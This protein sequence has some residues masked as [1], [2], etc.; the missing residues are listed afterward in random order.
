VLH[1]G[2]SRDG[3]GLLLRDI[4]RGEADVLAVRDLIAAARPD[5]LLLLRFDYDLEGVALAAFAERLAEAGHAMP[6][7]FALRPN[8]GWA[9]RLDLDGDGRSGTPDDAQGFGRFAGA[10]GKAILSR[11]PI[12]SAGVR[13]H[14]RFLWRD[15]PDALI[16]ERDGEP[17]PSAA[18]FAVQRL[19]STGHWE[20]PVATG[21][22]ERLRLLTWHAGPPAFGGP[23]QRNRRRNHDETVFWSRLLDGAL[24]IEPPEEPF[25]LMGNSNLD[26]ERGDGIH[27]AMQD[28]LAHPALQDPRPTGRRPGTDAP[29]TATAYWL[30]GPGAMRVGYI[31]PSAGLEIRDAG[32]VWPEDRGHALVWVE[33]ALP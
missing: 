7:R 17:F 16:P 31:L 18:V 10:G 9:T 2:L 25:V 23:E 33:I 19:S 15:L 22:G 11:L 21:S 27:T 12:D 29:D 3:P 20:V 5:V 32:L 4:R 6:Y 26:P 13:D 24:P 30:R 14:S 28:L 1:T 8:S